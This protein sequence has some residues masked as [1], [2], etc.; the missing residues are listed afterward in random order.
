MTFKT[1]SAICLPLMILSCSDEYSWHENFEARHAA[2][3]EKLEISIQRKKPSPEVAQAHILLGRKETGIAMLEDLIAKG[4]DSAY[5]VLAKM[6]DDGRL[7]EKDAEFAEQAFSIL[8]ESYIEPCTLLA[9]TFLTRGEF[10]KAESAYLSAA[11]FDYILAVTGLY[12]LY[13]KKG[14]S[15][16]NMEKSK[17]WAG[18]IGSSKDYNV[19]SFDGLTKRKP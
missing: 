17:Y 4:N 19:Y 10:E 2:N 1:I 14:W 6:R 3:L 7:I 18:K 13:A 16:H 12:R 11:E 9:Q 5:L 15:G 8:C